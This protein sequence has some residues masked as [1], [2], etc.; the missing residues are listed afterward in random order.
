MSMSD[1]G[2]VIWSGT[3]AK[4]GLGFE[5]KAEGESWFTVGR[6]VVPQSISVEALP[7]QPWDSYKPDFWWG[8]LCVQQQP[9]HNLPYFWQAPAETANYSYFT[10]VISQV[11]GNAY[12]VR[13]LSS[14]Q[15]GIYTGT[16]DPCAE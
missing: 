11:P 16:S 14:P 9:L 5:P 1:Q 4:W 10:P 13:N 6:P 8:I 2:D 15:G 3:E 7:K 12:R